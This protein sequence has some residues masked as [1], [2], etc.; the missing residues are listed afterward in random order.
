MQSMTDFLHEL[1]RA[2]EAIE[3]ANAI[4]VGIGSGM[5]ASGGLDYTDSEL[6]KKWY[7]EYYN[8]GL[9]TI[10]AI[11]GRYWVTTIGQLS[12][13][14]AKKYWG[15]WC[16]HIYHIRYEPEATE[17]YTLL[18]SLIGHTPYYIITTN[19]DHQT[20]KAFGKEHVLATQ[21]DYGYFQTVSGADDRLWYNE[22]MVRKMID[23]MPSAIEIRIQ[24]IPI[25]EE[26]GE[27]LEPNLRCDSNFV[28]LPWLEKLANYK[29]FIEEN[30]E[31]SILFWEIGVG[32]NTPTIIRWPFEQMAHQ[33]PN[34]TIIRM[35]KSESQLPD[36]LGQKGIALEGDIRERLKL[37][38][39]ANDGGGNVFLY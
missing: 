21:G 7:P 39:A 11:I 14:D 22:D 8:M 25:N 9:T 6:C 19:G 2:Q 27:R 15:F 34:A 33:Y 20:Q 1:E 12:D 37:L 4:V 10:G 24:D 35:N 36:T 13:E 16:R 32:F 30:N 17:P 31:R 3:N 23:N 18:R 5:S 28:E 29:R 38:S 26:T